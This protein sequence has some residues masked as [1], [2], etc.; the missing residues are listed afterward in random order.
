MYLQMDVFN[1][2]NKNTG[3]LKFKDAAPAWDRPH[4]RTP[5]VVGNSKKHRASCVS[6]V[7]SVPSLT[8]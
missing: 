5:P 8:G 4:T 7:L 1:C 2:Y 3:E 6:P